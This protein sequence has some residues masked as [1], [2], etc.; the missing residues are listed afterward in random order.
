MVDV[1]KA[2]DALALGRAVDPRLSR[3]LAVSTVLTNLLLALRP[4]WFKVVIDVVFEGDTTGA[5]RWAV[6]LAASEA[7][8]SWSLLRS[9]M[10]QMDL[11]DRG[12]EYIHRRCM[13]LT[14][15]PDGI[16]HLE[17]QEYLDRLDNLRGSFGSIGSA[18]ATV[19]DGIAVVLR[20]VVTLVLLM[21]V[22]PLFGLLPIFA[23]PA[24]RIAKAAEQRQQLGNLGAIPHTRLSEHLFGLLTMAAPAKEVRIFGLFGELAARERTAWRQSSRLQ[25]RALR[26][27]LL[28]NFAG[29]AIFAVGLL[30]SLV[31]VTREVGRGTA[32]AGDVFLVVALATQVNT[33]VVLAA[34]LVARWTQLGAALRE[35]RWL[36]A[37]T[38]RRGA[39][40]SP[41][42]VPNALRDG[43]VLQN[44]TF[45]YSENGDNALENVS[46]RLPAGTVV[47]LVGENGAGKSTLVKLLTGLYQPT[48]GEILVDGRPLDDFPELDW[49]ERLTVGFQ[50]FCRF[51]FI[52]RHSVGV[53][54]LPRHD[55][56]ASVANALKRT[57]AADLFDEMEDGDRTQLG[58]T[59][60][61]RELSGGQWQKVAIARSMMRT[62]PLLIVLDEP[63]ASLDPDAE[64]RVFTAYADAARRAARESGAITLLVSHRFSTVRMA[65][66]IL[67]L[68]DGRLTELGTHQELLENGGL[69]AE[70][71]RLQAD[72]YG[73]SSPDG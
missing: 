46:A 41:A 42:S 6:L 66:L 5:V 16:E 44:I 61:G 56:A 14:S 55:D 30:L 25:E 40:G 28:A 53:G 63:T 32:S 67:V 49:R 20:A 58:V 2:R 60:G 27:N 1:S 26:A 21:T 45:G 71:L 7:A 17:N 36:E 19:A 22:H 31:L 4:L 70:L 11:S 72:A 39:G 34:E 3:D 43:I 18:M 59:F 48:S 33:Q 68:E 64:F 12:T 73:A 62:A 8:R 35:L 69:Y 29:W 10:L 47:A 9:Q 15:A 57:S 54:D 23:L 52:A 24:L 13:N 37:E 50:D 38:G 65:D 51:E